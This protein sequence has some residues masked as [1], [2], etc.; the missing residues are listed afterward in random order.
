[1]VPDSILFFKTKILEISNYLTTLYFIHYFLL[2]QLNFYFCFVRLLV[3]K[4]NISIL[5][6]N[7]ENAIEA[8][9]PAAAA[10]SRLLK[11][12]LTLTQIYSQYASVSEQLL[13]EKEEN[14]KL[15]LYITTI[16]E[17]CICVILQL[18][19]DQSS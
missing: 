6:E 13:L 15:N 10:T 7:L 12:G 11:S 17:V 9:S 19:T 4:F 2:T 5:I 18:Y 16:L 3:L 14:R 1:M 8:V